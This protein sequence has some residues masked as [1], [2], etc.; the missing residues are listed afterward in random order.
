MVASHTARKKCL[1]INGTLGCTLIIQFLKVKFCQVDLEWTYIRT[2][3]I[4]HDLLR[5]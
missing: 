4:L 5:Q 3:S 1:P 2:Q